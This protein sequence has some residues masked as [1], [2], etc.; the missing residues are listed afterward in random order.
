MAKNWLVTGR[1]NSEVLT[2]ATTWMNP[3]AITLSERIQTQKVLYC[4]IPLMLNVQN[5]PVSRER[6]QISGSWGPGGGENWE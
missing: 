3:E 5:G 2:Q 1:K 4:M 6:R